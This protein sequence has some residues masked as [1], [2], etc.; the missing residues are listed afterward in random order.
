[1]GQTSQLLRA[2]TADSNG[3]HGLLHPS[4][5]GTERRY[6]TR[7]DLAFRSLEIQGSASSKE[8]KSIHSVAQVLD[9]RKAG[10]KDIG[11][12]DWF[13]ENGIHK[14]F[15]APRSGIV[16]TSCCVPTTQSMTAKTRRASGNSYCYTIVNGYGEQT[17][18]SVHVPKRHSKFVAA[19]PSQAV[20]IAG[21]A[22]L[23]TAPAPIHRTSAWSAS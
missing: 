6:D 7:D 5:N 10:N 2:A 9:L 11:H 18:N 4:H 15:L 8:G 3:L 12:G 14:H 1:M 20:A 22:P 21:A 23:P 13:R 17:V 19:S 16:A